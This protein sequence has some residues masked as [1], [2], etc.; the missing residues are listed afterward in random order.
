MPNRA[1][2][3]QSHRGAT[4]KALMARPD[5]EWFFVSSRQRLATGGGRRAIERRPA[6][7]GSQRSAV[8]K[9]AGGTPS[10]TITPP[11]V[12]LFFWKSRQ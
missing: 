6:V 1:L 3:R 10:P 2:I 8:K 12:G 9:A 11:G 4:A 7:A 5:R